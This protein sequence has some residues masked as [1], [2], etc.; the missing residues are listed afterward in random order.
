MHNQT[1]I[2]ARKLA[3]CRMQTSV[4]GVP[5]HAQPNYPSLL[6]GSWPFADCKLQFW[7]FEGMHNQTICHCCQ[8]VGHLQIANFSFG[9]SRAC[10]TN[11]SVHQCC[12]EAGHLQI[13]NFSSVLGVPAHAQPTYFCQTCCQEASHLQFANLSFAGS[14]AYATNL[15]VIIARKQEEWHRI[16]SA[17]SIAGLD[18]VI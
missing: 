2:V 10:T 17:G 16:R 5:E 7:G 1:V 4:L 14:R 8:E 3:I 6:P 15:S 12:Q 13:A 9:G 11:L 18:L